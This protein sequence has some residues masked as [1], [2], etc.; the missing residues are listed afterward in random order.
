M[1]ITGR[2]GDTRKIHIDEISSNTNNS[3]THIA[4]DIFI[5]IIGIEHD[6]LVTQAGERTKAAITVQCRETLGNEGTPEDV[7]YWGKQ[8]TSTNSDNWAD[9]PMRTWMQ[10]RLINVGLASTNLKTLIKPVI[11]KTLK[12][13]TNTGVVTSE[14]KVFWLS[15]SEVFGITSDKSIKDYAAVGTL[16]EGEQYEYYTIEANREKLANANADEDYFDSSTWWLRSP[17][18]LTNTTYGY[19]W[20]YVAAGG[21]NTPRSRGNNNGGGSAPAFCL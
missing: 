7:Y 17:S 5:V 8:R 16:L 3:K 1:E 20:F 14:D 10:N 2:Y 6:D 12:T 9:N 18:S 21:G 13:H 19:E 15:V 4:Q 11:K